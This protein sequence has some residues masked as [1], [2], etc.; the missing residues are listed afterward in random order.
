MNDRTIAIVGSR[1]GINRERVL[2]FVDHLTEQ[3]I[4]ISGG[5]SGVDTWAIERAKER[6][7]RTRVYPADW[8][9][10]GRGAGFHRNK[11]MV[12]LADEVAAFWDGESRGTA[13]TIKTAIEMRRPIVVF[14]PHGNVIRFVDEDGTV[15]EH[16]D[17]SEG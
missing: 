2:E 3:Y 11:V 14:S 12:N 16:S 7:L 13:H 9:K 1:K 15:Y 17:N 10:H 6:G 5:A 8:K 4:V